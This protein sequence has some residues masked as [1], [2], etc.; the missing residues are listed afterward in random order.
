MFFKNFVQVTWDGLFFYYVQGGMIILNIVSN[1][2]SM[3]TKISIERD[4][5]IVVAQHVYVPKKSKKSKSEHEVEQTEK[6]KLQRNLTDINSNVRRMD[7]STSVLAPL[8]A[9]GIMTFVK[10]SERFNGVIMS[11]LFFSIWNIVSL[12]FEY[13]LL[14]SVYNSVP[15]LKKSE[16]EN[17]EKKMSDKYNF[18][19]NLYKGWFVY[20]GQG[21]AMT[22]GLVLSIL[23]LT[24]LSFD[25][26]TIG[27]AKSQNLSESAISLLQ[28]LGSIAGLLGTFGFQYLNVK[29]KIA[30]S[31]VGL[32]GSFCQ[33]ICL[34]G[35]FLSIWVSSS[36]FKWSLLVT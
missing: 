8:F 28:A 20:F 24:V 23:H 12:F 4:W 1:L 29:R 10:I 11:A 30:L 15:H 14:T 33:I 16:S 17:K 7:L 3:T 6:Q 2:A 31:S 19:S 26:I 18:F 35:C 36:P 13:S 25:S 21:V 22:P 34:L 32:I 27:Y 5:V 9:G